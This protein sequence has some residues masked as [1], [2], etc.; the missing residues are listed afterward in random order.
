MIQML[1]T[2]ALFM[3]KT[4]AFFLYVEY[5][6]NMFNTRGHFP[7]VTI[8]KRYCYLRMIPFDIRRRRGRGGLNVKGDMKE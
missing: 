4:C 5:L 8:C 3:C 1:N 7:F 6:F 2:Y